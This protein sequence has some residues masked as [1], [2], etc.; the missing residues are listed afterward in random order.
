[1]WNV[2]LQSFKSGIGQYP[3]TVPSHVA[4][5]SS[6]REIYRFI[7]LAKITFPSQLNKDFLIDH[8]HVIILTVFSIH[9]LMKEVI[10][11]QFYLLFQ[12][13]VALYDTWS[14]NVF[15]LLLIG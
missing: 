4:A 7:V 13:S 2:C 9:H 15:K 3:I 14:C 6:F 11:R 12:V 10:K 1:M 8:I 5:I